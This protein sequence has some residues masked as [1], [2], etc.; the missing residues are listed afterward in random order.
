MKMRRILSAGAA[1]SGFGFSL[2]FPA[3]GVEA[4]NLVPASSRVGCTSLASI[5]GDRSRAMISGARFCRK[6]GR[7]CSQVG[8]AVATAPMISRAAVKCT[9]RRRWLSG[10]VTSKWG[11]RCGAMIARKR[12][13]WSWLRRHNSGSRAPTI[14]SSSQAGRKPELEL[15]VVFNA[16]Q[17]GCG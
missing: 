7:S 2:V 9:G 14:A 10:G 1:L 3:L 15:A 8:P 4:V 13:C 16:E 17:V 11:N 6:A 5:D 12:R